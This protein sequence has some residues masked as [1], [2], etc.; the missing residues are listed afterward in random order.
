MAIRCGVR[1]PNFRKATLCFMLRR[2]AVDARSRCAGGTVSVTG[3]PASRLFSTVLSLS[4]WDP[5]RAPNRQAHHVET[6][7][8]CS[9]KQ[10]N[11][12]IRKVQRRLRRLE[13]WRLLTLGSAGLHLLNLQR[14][15]RPRPWQHRAAN[16]L[17]Q[18]DSL[19][20]L[21]DD[22]VCAS[23]KSSLLAEAPWC[24]SR[25]SLFAR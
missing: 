6:C 2:D 22:H 21:P 10:S 14:Q 19:S 23:C 20:N 12:N 9:S 7:C 1:R 17:P 3:S 11:T 24:P 16:C 8:M 18:L 5:C 13:S 25:W 4:K 15:S